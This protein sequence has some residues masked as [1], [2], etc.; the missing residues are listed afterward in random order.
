MNAKSEYNYYQLLGVTKTATID[1]IKRAYRDLAQIYHPDSNFYNEIVEESLIQLTPEQEQLF[2]AITA[3]YHTLINEESRAEYDQ[4]LTPSLKGWTETK[5]VIDPKQVQK[6]KIQR[7]YAY[8]TF[9]KAS[10][11]TGIAGDHRS[12][13]DAKPVSEILFPRKKSLFSKICDLLG[14]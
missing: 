1:E 12:Y 5:I 8:G 10:K 14:I 3:A 6:A 2:K 7:P 9:G 11:K 4:T 13:N